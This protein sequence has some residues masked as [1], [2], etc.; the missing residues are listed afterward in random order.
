MFRVPSYQIA[1]EGEAEA[2]DLLSTIMGGSATSRIQK[3]IVLEQELATA[4][5]AF[6]QGSSRDMSSFGFYAVPRGDTNL[7]EVS[8]G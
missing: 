8:K 4:A 5:G 2:L 6:Y 1:E 3:E 7:D